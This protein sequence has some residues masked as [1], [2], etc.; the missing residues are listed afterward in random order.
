MLLV[1]AF[2]LRERELNGESIKY[3]ELVVGIAKYIH[4]SFLY[5]EAISFKGIVL[6]RLGEYDQALL[7]YKE[8]GDI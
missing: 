1:K 6:V 8:A 7:L 3:L 2:V 4:D 5:A